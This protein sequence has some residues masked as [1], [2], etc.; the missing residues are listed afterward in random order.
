MTAT[1]TGGT[2]VEVEHGFRRIRTGSPGAD[3]ILGGGFPADS[4]NIIMG[5]PG[6][7]KTVFAE[8]LVFHNA[9]SDEDDDRPAL[10]LTTLSEPLPKVVSYLQRFDFYDESKLGTAVI[11]D[12]LGAALA[13]S[14]VEV[15]VPRIREAI[16]TVSPKILVID[17]FK[18][19]HDLEPSPS[20]TRRLI[21]DLAGLLT[22]YDVTTFLV[23]EYTTEHVARYSEF[24]VADSV[25]EFA[26]EQLT[27]RDERYFRVLKLRGSSY[28]EGAHG[29]RLSEGGVEFFPRLVSPQLPEGYKLE[30]ERMPSGLD[31][32][33]ALIEGGLWRGSTTLVAGPTGSGKT[34]I[35]AQFALQ[36]IHDG[37]PALYVNF[38][39]N[40]TQFER[41]LTSLGMSEGEAERS[42]LHSIYTSPVELQIDS[43]IGG[44]YQLINE[45]GIRRVVIDA[46]GDLYTAVYD[47]Q[48]LHDYLYALTQHLTV[49][50]VT[51]VLTYETPT[52]GLGAAQINP[53]RE[54]GFS[55]VADN[56]FILTAADAEGRRSIRVLKT[57]NSGHDPRPHALV[58]GAS[59]ASIVDRIGA[60]ASEA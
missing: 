36:G 4:I 11:Y 24:A 53:T 49:S 46:V 23:G 50:G 16:T 20:A 40:P 14:G 3:D 56:I 18:V 25:V 51:S 27:S 33:D 6:S 29:M 45:A 7:G 9:S 32:L 13:E 34:T 2:G 39:E 59:G 35:A 26:R 5:R 22:A 57:R 41:L 54:L 38:Q 52:S 44:I 19:L 8:Q 1:T 31:G 30:L 58:L 12:D 47:A 10:Y 42:G 60:S 15:L 37:E 21:S 48:R 43:I 55:Y 28:R 17:S